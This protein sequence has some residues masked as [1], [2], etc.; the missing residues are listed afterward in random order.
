MAS[1]AACLF[2][3]ERVV[4]VLRHCDRS[5]ADD[6]GDNMKGGVPCW[7]SDPYHLAQLLKTNMRS[8]CCDLTKTP[9]AGRP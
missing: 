5:V 1:V 6:L 8:H 3:D 7:R 9:N 4:L 2:P